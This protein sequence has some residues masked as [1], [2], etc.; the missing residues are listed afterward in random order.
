MQKAETHGGDLDRV[1]K[2]FPQAPDPWIDLSTGIN[3]M[4]YPV[5]PLAVEAW[6]R[7]P[8]ADD[9]DKLKNVAACRY[10]ALNPTSIVLAPGTQALIQI[11]PRLLP[12]SEVAVIEPTYNEHARAWLREGHSVIGVATLE[13]AAMSN[14]SVVVVVN[15]NNPTGRLWPRTDLVRMAKMVSW[16]NGLLVVDEAFIDLL[17][18]QQSLVPTM[19]PATLVLRSFGKTYGLA[20]IRLGIA[21]AEPS[22]AERIADMIGPWAVSGPALQ[23]GA[24]ALSDTPWLDSTR[25]RLTASAQRLDAELIKGGFDIV[26]GTP[27]FRLASHRAAGRIAANLGRHGIH[28]RQFKRYPTWLRFGI[29]H[30]S[31]AWQ[32]LQLALSESAR[33]RC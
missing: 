5:P 24:K 21:V 8:Q 14:A 27:L 10:G 20:G 25:E 26:G 18:Q 4:P 3:P 31:E 12:P 22:I 17:D 32:R 23:V 16:R 11:L 15:P 29:P 28:V 13:Q 7:L 6:S 33:E 2:M 1:R 30:G 9:E 19:P